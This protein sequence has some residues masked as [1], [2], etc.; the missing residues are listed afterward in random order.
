MQPERSNK[1]HTLLDIHFK[2]RSFKH[3]NVYRKNM[4]MIHSKLSEHEKTVCLFFISN[5]Y[6][7]VNHKRRIKENPLDVLYMV[8][9]EDMN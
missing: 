2:F 7:P 6:I 8:H 4:V 9:L 5:S 3:F 1:Y